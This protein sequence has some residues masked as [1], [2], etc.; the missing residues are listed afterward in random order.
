MVKEECLA[1]ATSP[2][3]IGWPILEVEELSRAMAKLF[4]GRRMLE[5]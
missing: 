2:M 5:S 1:E 4:G 3:P